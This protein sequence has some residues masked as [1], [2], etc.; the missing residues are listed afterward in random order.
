[1]N[2]ACEGKLVPKR[3]RSRLTI[4]NDRSLQ[5]IGTGKNVP[6]IF[7]STDSEDLNEC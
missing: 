1:M 6:Q 4:S 2:H 7:E 5:A 3:F